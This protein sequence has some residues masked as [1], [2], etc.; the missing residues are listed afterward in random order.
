MSLKKYLNKKNYFK[1]KIMWFPFVS[2]NP[3]WLNEKM[4]E[5][6]ETRS[7]Y[8][9]CFDGPRYKPLISFIE[10][11]ISFLLYLLSFIIVIG[12]NVLL[13]GSLFFGIYYIFTG[14]LLLS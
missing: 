2:L 14:K 4:F 5:W 3:E 7:V 11:I 6:V 10:G 1:T 13:Y 8:K 12:L 9:R